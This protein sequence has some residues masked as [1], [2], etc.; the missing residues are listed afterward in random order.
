M[1]DKKQAPKEPGEAD[2]VSDA[3]EPVA[4]TAPEMSEP[5]QPESTVQDASDASEPNMDTPATESQEPEI[6]QDGAPGAIYV[7][8]DTPEPE[9]LAQDKPEPVIVRQGGFWPMLLGG[10]VAAGVGVAAAPY[11]LPP[12]WFA[13]E[14]S[15][16][17]AALAEQDARLTAL[18]ADLDGVQSPPDLSGEMQGLSETLTALTGQIAD[19]EGRIAALESRPATQGGGVP[20]AEIE[21]LRASLAAQAAEVEALRSAADAQEA[22]ARDSA[23]AT[24][25]RAALTQVLTALDTGS[26]FA[27]ALSDLRETGAE[28]PDVLADQAET[29]VPTQAALIESFPEAARAA[30]AAAR[31][32]SGDAVAGVGGFLKSQLGIR[33]LSPQEGDDPDA[34]L[35]RAEAA[36]A[37]GRLSDALTEIATLSEAARA[38]LDGWVA[39]ATRRQEALAAAEAL[40]ETV[41]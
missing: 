32:E 6:S 3:V 16:V 31:A 39:E 12:S 35:S 21:D 7:G 8:G 13:P 14:E 41:N 15:G 26:D 20:A 38:P 5:E 17:E 18:R 4:E 2:I 37:E 23:V 22:A 30:L 27:P 29:G 24:L 11:V 33:S 25:R 36:L 40:A 28:V 10:V 19:L 1:A 9:P 34:V